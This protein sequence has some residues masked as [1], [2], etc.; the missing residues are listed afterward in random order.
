MLVLYLYRRTVCT[1]LFLLYNESAS[2]C[3]YSYCGCTITQCVPCLYLWYSGLAWL[4]RVMCL[5]LVPCLYYC[6]VRLGDVRF[7][8]LSSCRVVAVPLHSVYRACTF[9]RCTCAVRVLIAQSARVMCVL[10]VLYSCRACTIAQSSRVMYVLPVLYSCRAV[11]VPLHRVLYSRSALTL[12]MG[13]VRFT[14]FCTR[15]VHVLLHS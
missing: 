9:T 6:T 14:R 15:V 3:S 2:P 11:A 1:V 12:S 8:R 4:A 10:P 7:T 13:N 5:L